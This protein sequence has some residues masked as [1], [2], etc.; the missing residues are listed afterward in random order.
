VRILAKLCFLTDYD[1]IEL[2]KLV[3]TSFSDVIDITSLKHV[4][5]LTSLIVFILGPS[6][7]KFLATPVLLI[8]VMRKSNQ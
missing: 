5:K 4:I 7:S 1:E 2:K 3:M 8:L 6:Q